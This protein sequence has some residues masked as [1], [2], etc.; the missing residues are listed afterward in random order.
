MRGERLTGFAVAALLAVGAIAGCGGDDDGDAG[1]SQDG[2]SEFVATGSDEQQ[3]KQVLQ[4]IQKDFDNVDGVAYCDKVTKAEQKDIIGYGRNFGKGETCVDVIEAVARETKLSGVEQKPTTFI[5]AQ[6]NGDRA[7]ARVKNGPRPPE[8]M[9]FVKE[10]GEWK[11]IESGL[12]PDP[13]GTII[14]QGKKAKKAK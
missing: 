5:S 12:N 2:G 6:V 1:A 13:I 4:G 11:V 9:P 3:I 10:G 7:R 14:Q 8:W